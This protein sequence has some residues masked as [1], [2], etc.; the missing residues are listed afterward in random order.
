[1]RS[2][3]KKKMATLQ[4]T[5]LDI[6]SQGD[7]IEESKSNLKEAIELFFEHASQKEIDQRLSKA[8]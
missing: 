3:K 2:L 5:K 8:A 7:S 6:A 1:M 4:C